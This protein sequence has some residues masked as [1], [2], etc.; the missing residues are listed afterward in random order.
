MMWD[1]E[2]HSSRWWNFSNRINMAI[3]K[4]FWIRPFLAAF[5]GFWSLATAERGNV[6]ESMRSSWQG[7][8]LAA[9]QFNPQRERFLRLTMFY[10]RGNKGFICIYIYVIIRIYKSLRVWLWFLLRW[11]RGLRKKNTLLFCFLLFPDLLFFRMFFSAML[12]AYN[13]LM[14]PPFDFRPGSF[15]N[16]TN[17][18]IPICSKPRWER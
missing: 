7:R 5:L 15:R 16:R 1:G 12:S 4:S 3:F 11:N 9:W 6:P 8:P 10:S 18:F 13:K 14:Q 17:W 2:G